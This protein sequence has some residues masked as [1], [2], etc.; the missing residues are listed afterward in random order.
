MKPFGPLKLEPHVL[1]V[2]IKSNTSIRNE[3]DATLET[4]LQWYN[5]WYTSHNHT[6][7]D[8]PY[9]KAI[10]STN[11]RNRLDTAVHFL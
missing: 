6:E 4:T 1:A 5:R 2:E 10:T 8:E 9:G 3:M 7:K 11:S